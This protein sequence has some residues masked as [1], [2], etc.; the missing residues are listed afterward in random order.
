MVTLRNGFYVYGFGG[1]GKQLVDFCLVNKLPCKMIYDQK[2][3]NSSYHEIPIITPDVADT[4]ADLP[5]IMAVHNPKVNLA[6][7][8]QDLQKKGFSEVL[9]SV[10]AYLLIKQEFML[11]CPD[12]YWLS[13]LIDW[14]DTE[15]KN[16]EECLE[17]HASKECFSKQIAY[18]KTGNYSLLPSTSI[19]DQY[20]PSD[21][22]LKFTSPIFFVDCG[23]YTGDTIE[24]L[25]KMGTTFRGLMCFEPD[26]ENFIKL[27]QYLNSNHSNI[28]ATILPAGIS[29][30]NTVIK[31]Q[32]DGTEGSKISESGSISIPCFALQDVVVGVKPDYIKMD[33]EGAEIEALKGMEKIIIKYH[34]CLA[35]S[36]YHKPKDLWQIPLY[37]KELYAGYKIYLKMHYENCFETVCYAIPQ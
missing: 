33:I 8:K 20:F 29:N 9:N 28:S 18:R 10:E 1:F 17:D 13:V 31:F 24:F 3:L 15:I 22:P 21:I 36:V 19:D 27:G 14:D 6:T 11:L 7:L 25:S 30:E 5:C 35:I 2:P 12:A 37:L 34:P 23:A 26:L 16:A 4:N 32:A